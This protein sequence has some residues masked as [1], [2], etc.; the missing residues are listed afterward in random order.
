MLRHKSDIHFFFLSTDADTNINDIEVLMNLKW[1]SVDDKKN[2]HIYCHARRSA[3]TRWAEIDDI[4]SFGENPRV[5]IIDSSYLSVFCLKDNVECHPISFVNIDSRTATVTSPFRSMI[6]GFGETGE[7]TFKFLYEFGAFVNEA[8]RKTKFHCTIIDKQA[9]Q[10]EGLFYAKAPTMKDFTDVGEEEREL[11]FTECSIDSKTYWETIEWEIRQGLNYIVVAIADEELAINTAVNIC[12]LAT[13]WRNEDPP[14]LNVYVRSYSSDGYG[15]MENIAKELNDKLENIHLEI[16]GGMEKMFQYDMIVENKYIQQAKRYNL[17]YESVRD[18]KRVVADEELEED[19]WKMLHHNNGK[20]WEIEDVERRKDQNISNALHA[21]T[22][23]KLLEATGRSAEEWKKLS[24]K[25]EG[26][27]YPDMDN[28]LENILINVAKCEH[29]RWVSFSRL[30]GYS[31]ANENERGNDKKE[32]RAKAKKH[33]DLVP[34]D[35]IQAWN[36]DKEKIIETQGYDCAVVD[37]TIQ[38]IQV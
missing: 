7:E 33:T 25:H 10:M 20:I 23:V 16:F 12:T 27:K 18:G 24:P 2:F 5:H 22:K 34:W 28:G 21:K 8:G 15:R 4:C 36:P 14:K 32:H 11:C 17:A 6:I 29:E 37:T 9:T 30:Q 13:R 38:L 26:N 35:E 19:K 31:L 3:K 1:S